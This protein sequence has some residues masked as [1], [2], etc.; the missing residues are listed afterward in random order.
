M[1]TLNW[2][3]PN[4]TTG[5]LNFSDIFMLSIGTEIPANADLDTYKTPGTYYAQDSTRAKT[6]SNCPYTS[7]NF[8]LVVMTGG[9]AVSIC[10]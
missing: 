5:S 4:G 10:I 8:K 2:K 6:L 1:A 7:S 9:D 3:T